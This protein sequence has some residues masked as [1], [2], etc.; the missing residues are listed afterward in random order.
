MQ[1]TCVMNKPLTRCKNSFCVSWVFF[2]P[3]VNLLW[4]MCE[5]VWRL[6]TNS[7]VIFSTFQQD[8]LKKTEIVNCFYWLEPKKKSLNIFSWKVLNNENLPLTHCSEE[9]SNSISHLKHWW[10]ALLVDLQLPLFAFFVS[11]RVEN[12]KI[13][14]TSQQFLL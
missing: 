10:A 1:W 14:S 3:A 12:G 8:W 11:P 13:L 6:S 7:V 2:F 9:I 4:K 5:M